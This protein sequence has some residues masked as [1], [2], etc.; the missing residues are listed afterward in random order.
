[1]AETQ[2]DFLF[3][4]IKSLSKSEK[5]LFRLYVNRLGI[6]TDAK[7]LLLFDAIDKMQEY[8]EAKLLEKKITT[9]LQLSNLKAHLY[10]QILTSLRFNPSNQNYWILLREQ[11]DFATILYNKGLYKQAL[12]VLDKAKQTAI[13]KE[14][15]EIAY[16]IVEL[17]KVIESQFITRSI[18]SRADDLI[19]DAKELS[20]LN[21]LN[22]KLSNLSLK[23]YSIMLANGYAKND[24]QKQHIIKYFEDN[25]PKKDLE[26]MQFR[27]K[28]WFYK[29]HVWKNLLIQDF[30]SAYKYSLSWTNLFYE[31]PEMIH[32]HPVW[33]VKGNNYLLNS[34]FILR[35]ADRFNFWLEKFEQTLEKESFPK[36][37]NVEAVAFTNLYN[38]RIN[39][40]FLN[41][42][43]EFSDH[44]I[45]E[46]LHHKEFYDDKIDD[47]H[48]LILNYKIASLYFGKRDYENA[49][50]ELSKIIN[51]KNSSVRDDLYFHSRI[52]MLITMVDSG[53]DENL[54]DF[55]EETSRFFKKMKQPTDFHEVTITLFQNLHE[56]FPDERKKV[57]GDFLEKFNQLAKNEFNTRNFVYLNIISWL[58]SIISS[59]TM[60]EVLKE[61]VR[62]QGKFRG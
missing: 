4:L 41:G 44:L 55:L 28:L 18:N 47:H 24:A 19:E 60:A 35:R 16:E 10:H 14:E 46:I 27:E 58:E 62:Q 5:R 43:Y 38:A 39:S 48:I 52:L 2:K 11:Q 26:L 17:E 6:N 49:M 56:A 30:I 7:F 34:L 36:N 57:A 3:V 25:L 22:S 53:I 45:N 33:F 40:V 32:F 42:D 51:H 59:R 12:K 13:D 61:K 9:K 23:L 21:A 54:E 37:E 20:K 8:S 50:R 31:N 1:M 29:A 15:K